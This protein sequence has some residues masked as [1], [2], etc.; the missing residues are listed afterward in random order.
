VHPLIRFDAWAHRHPD[1][2]AFRGAA[3]RSTYAELLQGSISVAALICSVLG[4]DG[5]PVALLGHKEPEM[6]MAFLG[7]ARSGHPYIPLDSASPRQRVEQ[8]I[9]ISQARLVLT[10]ERVRAA[11]AKPTRTL[12]Q[13]TLLEDDHPYYIMF[14]SGSTGEPK[15]VTITQRNLSSFLEWMHAEHDLESGA[16]TFLNQAPFNF[17]LSVMDTYLSLT[18]GG[19]LVSLTAREVQTPR[20]LYEAL[21]TSDITTW[22]STPSFAL[23][24]L[25]EPSFDGRML[26]RLRRFLFCGETL[27]PS[28][29]KQLLDRFPG[30]AVWNTYGPTEATVA[31]TSIRIERDLLRRYSALPVGVPKPGTRITLADDVDGRGEIVI[32]GSN[33]SPGYLNRPDLTRSRFFDLDGL[34]AYRTGDLGHFQDGLLFFDGRLDDQIKL[35]GY[36]IEIGDVESN[37]RCLSG[38]HEAVVVPLE[39]NR[40]IE[41]LAAFVRVDRLT[42][43]TDFQASLRIRRDLSQ[44]VPGYMLPRVIQLVDDWPLTPNGKVDRR[45][46]TSQLT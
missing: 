20:L 32:A 25:A 14:T 7:S 21:R 27:A 17:D 30:A 13:H 28:L 12:S 44:R 22:V 38:V 34:P 37:L 18:T 5:S 35:N 1:R 6:L 16:E 36:R 40:R 4:D 10:P 11:L 46:L 31:T 2:L 43:E 9:A 23:M 24:C 3:G 39:R 26:P 19:T 42:S 8:A 29:A 41:A 33:V 15:G 45:A